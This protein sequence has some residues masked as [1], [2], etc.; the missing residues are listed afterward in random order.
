MRVEISLLLALLALCSSARPRPAVAPRVRSRAPNVCALAR[1]RREQFG[2]GP[3]RLSGLFVEFP[4]EGSEPPK[5]ERA[6]SEDADELRRS[7][8]WSTRSTIQKQKWSDVSV[9]HVEPAAAKHT[10]EACEHM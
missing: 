3:R 10:Q 4:R 9:A 8:E 1:P 2:D 5:P 6:K 7:W